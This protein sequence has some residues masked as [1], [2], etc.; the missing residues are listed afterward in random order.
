MGTTGV[1]AHNGD[2][3]IAV[4]GRSVK[5]VANFYELLENTQGEQVEL[6]LNNKP[7]SKGAWQITVKPI[8]S[9]QG[10]RYLNWVNSRA[11]Y[12]DKLSS[13]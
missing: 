7:R 5:D 8:A 12:V 3:I 11:A 6:V 1:K 10:L 2:Y 9:E 4:N 13:G